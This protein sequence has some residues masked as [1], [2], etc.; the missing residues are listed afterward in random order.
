MID[1]DIS[2]ISLN[3]QYPMFALHYA[4]LAQMTT[5][6]SVFHAL[7]TLLSNFYTWA[8]VFSHVLEE[9]LN[10]KTSV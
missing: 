3:N 4:V 7:L 9:K 10:K 2:L 5:T 6:L 8:S 1:K